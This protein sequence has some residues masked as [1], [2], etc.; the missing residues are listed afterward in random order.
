MDEWGVLQGSDHF[1]NVQKMSMKV[2]K[3]RQLRYAM[4]SLC[5]ACRDRTIL[6]CSKEL[7][8]LRS[9]LPFTCQHNKFVTSVELRAGEDSP[10]LI[11]PRP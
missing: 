3:S 7:E 2:P 5:D 9:K 4:G 8:H 6:I 11:T 1:L 10:G